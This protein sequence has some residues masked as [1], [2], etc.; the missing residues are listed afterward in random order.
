MRIVAPSEASSVLQRFVE[1]GELP[2]SRLTCANGSRNPQTNIQ[3]TEWIVEVADVTVSGGR[4]NGTI[5]NS[6]SRLAQTYSIHFPWRVW[7]VDDR[8]DQ[9]LLCRFD[10]QWVSENLGFQGKAQMLYTEQMA[11]C[12]CLSHNAQL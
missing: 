9:K 10:I 7:A 5:V 3:K 8:I 4:K 2:I 1:N 6:T 12:G 11:A